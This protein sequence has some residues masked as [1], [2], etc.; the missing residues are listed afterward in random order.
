[1]V[2][3]ELKVLATADRKL[4]SIRAPGL[5]SAELSLRTARGVEAELQASIAFCLL[6]TMGFRWEEPTP[7]FKDSAV[8]FCE[9]QRYMGRFTN[10]EPIPPVLRLPES[11]QSKL[12]GFVMQ[13][14]IS[15]QSIREGWYIGAAAPGFVPIGYQDFEEAQAGVAGQIRALGIA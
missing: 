14:K 9:D 3:D 11:A 7:A 13:Q 6:P 15:G 2:L 10:S 4:I 1:M 8:L 12:C 5:P